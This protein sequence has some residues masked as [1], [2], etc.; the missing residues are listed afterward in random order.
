MNRKISLILIGI[1]LT[2]QGL[3][4]QRYTISGYVKDAGSGEELISANVYD[5]KSNNGTVTNTYGFYSLS[6]EK[7]SIYLEVSYIG[8]ETKS[9]A[10]YLD[11]DITLNIDL[12]SSVTLDEVEISAERSKRIEEQSQMS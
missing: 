4:A 5:Y 8:Y 6:L 11:K 3:N 9:F 2:V 7:D 1:L 12:S 10:L